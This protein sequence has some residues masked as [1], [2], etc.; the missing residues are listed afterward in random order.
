MSGSRGES[1]ERAIAYLLVFA[2]FEIVEQPF[3]VCIEGKRVG[4]LDILLR[5]PETGV[6]IGCSCKDWPSSEYVPGSSEFNHFV[7]MLEAVNLTYGIFASRT[8]V[9]EAVETLAKLESRKGKQILL[10]DSTVYEKFNEWLK[11]KRRWQIEDYIREELKLVRKLEAGPQLNKTIFLG[12]KTITVENALP[13][14]LHHSP[15]RYIENPYFMPVEAVLEYRPFLVVKYHLYSSLRVPR[16][17]E[18][19]NEV[20][21]T[22]V[23]VIDGHSG[24][25]LDEESI[26]YQEL[27]TSFAVAGGY[28]VEEKGFHVKIIEPKI[29]R[30]AYLH[31]VKCDVARTYCEEI[32][33]ED[34]EGQQHIYT[35]SPDPED[36]T[37]LYGDFVYLPIWHVKFTLGSHIYHRVYTGFGGRLIRDDMA[38]C[39]LCNSSTI[40]VCTSCGSTVCKKH[41]VAC[42]ICQTI[43]CNNC[44]YQCVKCRTVFC[45]QHKIGEHCK[46]CGAF[47]C[48]ECTT[49]CSVCN[50][51][52]C[53]DHVTRCDICSKPICS[54]HVIQ[55]KYLLRAKK[56][57][58][59]K[60]EKDFDDAYRKTGRLGRFKKAYFR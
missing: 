49:R 39:L 59:I 46:D 38:K 50:I 4:D 51:P 44:S 12:G 21:D 55:A 52:I 10:I 9:S 5:D 45:N 3:W 8:G 57:C 36:V 58:S 30:R 47:L 11:Q 31:K 6:Y 17:N 27:N 22:G 29:D 34:E 40:A 56:F 41:K 7:K 32:K 2:G 15:P 19:I 1:F 14:F 28:V 25:I 33:Y 53:P 43:L 48:S 42:S 23:E 13:L 20:T 35:H 54:G 18:L 16:T 24:K 26:F 60:C 37:I